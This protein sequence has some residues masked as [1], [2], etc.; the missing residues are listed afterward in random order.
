MKKIL[1]TLLLIV[2]YILS[3]SISVAISFLFRIFLSHLPLHVRVTLVTR[4]CCARFTFVLHALHVRVTLSWT[5]RLKIN[6]INHIN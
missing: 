6:N 2:N 4:T 5:K 3:I 1:Y